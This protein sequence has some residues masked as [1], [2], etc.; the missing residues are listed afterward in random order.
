[1]NPAHLH[2]I[3]NH[4]PI[5]TTVIGI[6][7]LIW[8]MYKSNAS[9]RNIAFVLFILGAVGS[10]VAVETGESAEDIVEEIA[11]VSHDTIHDHEEAAEI[12]MWFA[13]VMGFLS[14]GALASKKLNL[15]FETGLHIVILIMALITAGILMYVA[16]EGGEIMHQEAYAEHVQSI[17][18]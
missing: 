2:L 7:I 11:T 6:F 4:I 5:F 13:I 10:Y 1:M 14:I 3:V 8:G 15:R 18:D 12:S 9:V 16:Y 17:D